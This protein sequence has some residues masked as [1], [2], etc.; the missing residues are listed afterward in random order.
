[1][2]QTVKLRHLP[3]V[4]SRVLVRYGEEGAFKSLT[5]TYEGRG[6]HT[7]GEE[8]IAVLSHKRRSRGLHYQILTS[9]IVSMEVLDA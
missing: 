1:M 3:A 2:Q 9:M 8:Y 4:G 6:V 7:S 5:G